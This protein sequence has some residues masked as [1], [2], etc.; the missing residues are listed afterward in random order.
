MNDRLYNIKETIDEG[1]YLYEIVESGGQLGV[2][3]RKYVKTDELFEC[4]NDIPLKYRYN[5]KK[6]I[7]HRFNMITT[8]FES[9]VWCW[10]YDE[11]N[12]EI[13][14]EMSKKRVN[15]KIELKK[16]KIKNFVHKIKKYNLPKSLTIN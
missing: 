8:K 7:S 14:K 4:I 5:L 11:F 10:P 16:R 13:G 15:M 12:L 3:C 9:I 2:R 1:N 6:F